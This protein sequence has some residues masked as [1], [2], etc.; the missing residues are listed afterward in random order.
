MLPSCIRQEGGG[1]FK[2]FYANLLNRQSNNPHA[3]TSIP[4][5]PSKSDLIRV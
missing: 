2:I 5:K 1:R 3:K 4:E